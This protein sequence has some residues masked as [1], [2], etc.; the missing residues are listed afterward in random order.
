MTVHNSTLLDKLRQR[1]REDLLRMRA[2]GDSLADEWHAAIETIFAERGEAL[3]PMPSRPIDVE[4]ARE[5]RKGDGLV[6]CGGL[7]IALILGGMLK[8]SWLALPIAVAVVLFYAVKLFR[9]SAL[10]EEQRE[11]EVAAEKAKELG[12]NELMR[13]AADGDAVRVREILQY[14]AADVNA[15][16][17]AGATALVYAARNGHL[18][19][20]D[21]LLESG[22]R[23]DLLTHKGSSATSV[24]RQFGHD[25]IADKLEFGH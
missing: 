20:V 12:L 7:L 1:S 19:I 11:R 10:P 16:C 9:R 18:E 13:C 6:A 8:S 24:A 2:E 3:P 22:A 15:R 25:S 17:P 4:P 23:P 21:L 5:A 14:A